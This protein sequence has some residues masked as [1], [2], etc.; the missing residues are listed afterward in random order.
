[1]NQKNLYRFLFIAILLYNSVI[2]QSLL[3]L[4]YPMGIPLRSGAGPSLSICGTGVG[5]GNDY[6]GLANNP[7]NLGTVGRTVFSTTLSS[8]LLILSDHNKS[9][10]NLDMN[11]RLFALSIPIGSLGALGLSFEPYSNAN[12]RFRLLRKIDIDGILTDTAEL[13][14][15]RNGG[16]VRWQIGWGG[17]VL[18]HLRVGIAYQRLNFS[19]NTSEITQTR[20]SLHDCLTDSTMVIFTA[21]G[22]R[23]GVQ[24]PFDR[25]T[26]GISGDYFIM[27][28]ARSTNVIKGTRDTTSIIVNREFYLKPPP[29]LALGFS[30][31]FSQRLFAA[32][33]MGAV[34]WDRFYSEIA[35]ADKQ[36][37][38]FF[39]SAGAQFVP[40]PDILNPKIYEVIQ[41]R[42]GVR[43]AGLPVK[44]GHEVAA[45]FGLGVPL[46]SS[47]GLLDIIFEFS[48]RWDDR[49][50][51]YAENLFSLKFG[52]NGGRKWHKSGGG[53]Y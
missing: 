49:F 29:L 40:A 3:S 32:F 6:F 46:Q 35:S 45:S 5:V 42:G 33:D 47:G 15:I 39:V 18:K 1:M 19:Q 30:W 50:I 37:K 14:L 36:N 11:L 34:M 44:D 43:Y 4:Q 31:Q 41:Y 38:A 8:E 13:G 24:M 48:R 21:D 23:A 16:A 9:T 12:T 27:N 20:G 17:A 52:I 51:E 28:R 2:S 22:I 7:A 10:Q 26:I 53:S 25:L